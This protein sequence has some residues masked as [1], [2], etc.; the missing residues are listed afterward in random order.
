MA[1]LFCEKN[2]AGWWLINKQKGRP[3]TMLADATRSQLKQT[4]LA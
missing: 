2:N 4:A 1:D 3:Q